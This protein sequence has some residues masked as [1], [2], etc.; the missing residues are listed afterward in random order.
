MP[1][2][3]NVNG[4]IVSQSTKRTT[5]YIAGMSAAAGAFALG[6]ALGE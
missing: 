2:S 4:D 3:Y 5:Q 6:T 1:T